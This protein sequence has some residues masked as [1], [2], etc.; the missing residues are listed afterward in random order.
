MS[1]EKK[2]HVKLN[3]IIGNPPYQDD[4]A[5][6]NHQA[7]PI[8]HNFM[9]GSYS[10]GDIVELIT[11]A[12]FL[13]LS[14]AT[15][16][17]WDRKML[18]SRK[19]K[20]SY[21]NADS[22]QVF[23]NVDIKGGVVVTFYKKDADFRPIYV[24]IP[25]PELQHVYEKVK[26]RSQSFVSD[27]I[28][29][30]D[31]F[32]FTDD[33]FKENPVLIGRTDK[34]HAK[35]VASSVFDRYP[36]IFSNTSFT[37]SIGIIG[38]K[39]NKRCELYTKQIYLRDPGDLH[40]YKLLVPGASGTGAFGETLAKPII[41]KPM[42]A[43]T[44]TFV[45]ISGLKSIDEANALMNYI[46]TKFFRSL[47][48]IMKTTQNNQAKRTWSLVPWQDFT[49]SSDIDWNKSVH[50]IDLQLY[51]KYGLNQKEIDFIETH[52]KEMD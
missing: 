10:I 13:S 33:L 2:K 15:P 31:S 9:D 52:V 26:S 37:N 16:K 17:K 50:E 11:P 47:L 35:A 22:R 20:I 7:K 1:D 43:H 42:E 40:E 3:V 29:S 18:N 41:A 24:F 45:A 27:H 6:N 44:Q 38:R 39:D 14:G 36:E 8:Y 23:S 48:F 34:S 51:K 25:Q 4:T 5:G 46:K 19:V 28:Y 12:R 49:A 32:R 21:F 30:P